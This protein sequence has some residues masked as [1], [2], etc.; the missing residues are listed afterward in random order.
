MMHVQATSLRRERDD[1]HLVSPFA[2]ILEHVLADS[3]FA[4]SYMS[5]SAVLESRRR[6]SDVVSKAVVLADGRAAETQ[7][8][9]RKDGAG[10]RQSPTK[11]SS[12]GNVPGL[13]REPYVL[14]KASLHVQSSPRSASPMP[15]YRVHLHEL[16]AKTQGSIWQ[17]E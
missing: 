4:R 14:R 2:R 9:N 6:T 1:A 5:L 11:L 16:S 12:V 17:I 15:S 10:Y 7:P 8:I 13:N 3:E